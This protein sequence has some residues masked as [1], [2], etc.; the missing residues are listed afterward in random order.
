MPYPMRK[1]WVKLWTQETLYGTTSRE[2]S[3]EQQAIWFKFLALA[4][5]SPEPG[6]ICA[7][8]NLPYTDEQLAYIVGAPIETLVAAKSKME[9]YH[10][11]NQDRSGIHILKWEIY[12]GA[13][14]AYMRD[15]MRQRRGKQRSKQN[16][17]QVNNSVNGKQNGKQ[18]EEEGEEEGR[19]GANKYKYLLGFQ[20]LKDELN[21]RRNKKDKIGLL[22]E[23]FEFHHRNAPDGDFADLGG[24]IAAIL[25][26]INNDY[27]YFLKLIWDTASGNIAGSHL[28]YI[29]GIIR[30]THRQTGELVDSGH[31]PNLSEGE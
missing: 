3:L 12:Q 24:R 9:E 14:T 25:K 16:G 26:T 2:L 21:E 4:G 8:P 6:I 13:R 1:R 28:G 17:K 29:Q 7:A 30:R 22:V 23:T 15:Y 18:V 31:Y 27:G 5:D 10:K 11:I 19:G 20:S